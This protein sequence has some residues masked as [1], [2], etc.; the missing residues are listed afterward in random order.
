MCKVLNKRVHG[1]PEGAVYVGRPTKWG[2]P[3]SHQAGT[4]AKYKVATRDE[5]VD[6]YEQYLRE[7]PELMEA[8]KRELR[9]KD[10][11]CWCAPLRCH[12]DVL[13]KVANEGDAE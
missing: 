2:N 5:A 11:V 13:V 4:L 1:I 12:A 9:G 7:N 10:L 6:A 3:F 8:A